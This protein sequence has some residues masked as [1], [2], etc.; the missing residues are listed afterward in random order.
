MIK[1]FNNRVG[2]NLDNINIL[3][4]VLIGKVVYNIG[5]S[6]IYFVFGIFVGWGF[7]LKLFD[8]Y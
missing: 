7:V 2:E 6:I 8:M 1:F 3:L 5:G 4:C